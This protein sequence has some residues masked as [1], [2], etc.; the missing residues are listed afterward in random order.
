MATCRPLR[1]LRTSHIIRQQ[2]VC[3]RQRWYSAEGAAAAPVEESPLH[4]VEAESSL[5]GP[6][7]TPEQLEEF[8]APWKRALQRKY[9]L[10]ASRYASQPIATFLHR[11]MAPNSSRPDPNTTRQDSTAG[12][13][14][15]SNRRPR[16]KSSPATSTPVPSTS[17]ASRRRS[18]T[19]SRPTSSP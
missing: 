10:P 1:Q 13:Y 15:P 6:G 7:P 12:H 17:P 4:D 14:I 19:Q 8:R 2:P 11:D 16:P 3:A 18:S 9:Q 5:N